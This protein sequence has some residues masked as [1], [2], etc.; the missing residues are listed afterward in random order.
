MNAQA[1]AAALS[2]WGRLKRALFLALGLMFVFVLWRSERFIVDHSHPAWAYYA[3]VLWWLVPDGLG[4]LIAR[5]AVHHGRR[6]CGRAQGPRADSS[7]VD[8]GEL[9]HYDDVRYHARSDGDTIDRRRGR[10]HLRAGTM[11][12][13]RG[14]DGAGRA[15]SDVAC[16]VRQ[17]QTVNAAESITIGALWHLT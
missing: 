16:A 13:S 9:R 4:G 8:G 12:T 7:S 11:V 3:P 6:I 10:G 17:R 1:V 5:A 2:A 14:D 15:W